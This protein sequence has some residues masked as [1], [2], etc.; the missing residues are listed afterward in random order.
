[1]TSVAAGKVLGLDGGGT[2][3][4]IA[5]ADPAGAVL[6]LRQVGSLDPIAHADW[7]GAM[8][9][10][11]SSVGPVDYAVLGLPYHTEIP[12]LSA[13][14]RAVAADIFG[15]AG[16]VVNDVAVAF[17]GAM[18]GTDGVLVLAGTGS[19][20]W[21]RGP[22]G[23]V[24]CG[25]WGDAIGDEGSA[26][27]IGREA[28]GRLS[29]HLDGRRSAS[30]FAAA[31]LAGLGLSRDGLIGWIYGDG[32]QR[33]RI[34]SVAQ[35]VARLAAGGQPEGRAE[36][37]AILRRAA[38]HLVVL[39]RVTAQRCG[40][41]GLPRWSYAGGVFNSAFLLKAVAQGIGSEP[42]AP[43]LPPVG[44]ALLLAAQNAGWVVDAAFLA[45]LKREL[46]QK[47]TGI[48]HPLAEVTP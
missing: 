4:M 2:K 31:I 48:S 29:Q 15:A 9:L 32:G 16:Q 22:A 1:M 26:H 14:Q 23:T 3:T 27:W 47:M 21:G 36:A 30:D 25:G 35:V 45:R 41:P 38:G 5:V 18:A 12:Q 10:A 7:P 28:L 44:G 39:A 11:L 34:A 46:T 40:A 6:D 20:A 13:Q 8:T 43:C 24:R 37:Q 42:I 33:A 19:M 17:A